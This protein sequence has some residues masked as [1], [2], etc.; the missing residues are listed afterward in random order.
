[1]SCSGSATGPEQKVSSC[2]STASALG[3]LKGV[4]KVHQLTAVDTFTR[5]AIVRIVH[6]PVTVDIAIQFFERTHRQWA[7]LGRPIKAIVADNGPEYIATRFADALARA[8]ITPINIPAQNPH[9][10]GKMRTATRSATC[11]Q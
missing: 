10:A 6:G 9:G 2:R 4:G 8:E 5:W 3:N 7:R 1:M 11:V